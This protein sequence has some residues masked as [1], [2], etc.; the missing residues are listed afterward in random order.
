V[1]KKSRD[2][3]EIISEEENGI[4]HWYFPASVY[5]NQ[6]QGNY[7]RNLV[8]LLQLHIEN[9]ENLIFHLNYNQSKVLADRLKEVFECKVIAV[10]HYSDWGFTLQGN[11]SRLRTILKNEQPDD[12]EKRIQASVEFDK[13][14]YSSVDHIICLSEY[15]KDILCN[16]YKLSHEKISVVPNGLSDSYKRINKSK[17]RKKWH[18]TKD[19][20]I[21]LFAGRL[22]DI[23]GLT[24]LIAAFRE[25][26]KVY[27]CRLIIAGDGNFNVYMKEAKDICT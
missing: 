16:D 7:Y 9:K 6:K 25:V 5:N 18:F 2:K 4:R 20:K 8:Y 22:N 15:M 27:P 11:I 23:K 1:Q 17:L 21:I 3:D 13:S 24:Y 19:E 12:F 26:L 10:V 14:F